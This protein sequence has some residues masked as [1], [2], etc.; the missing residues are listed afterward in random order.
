MR[1]VE[2]EDAGN[3]SE[4]RLLIQHTHGEAKFAGNRVNALQITVALQ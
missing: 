2:E 3:E 4:M 1:C